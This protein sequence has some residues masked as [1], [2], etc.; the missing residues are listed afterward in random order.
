MSPRKPASLTDYIGD[1][2][3]LP[4]EVLLGHVVL[5]RI[6]DGAYDRDALSKQMDLLDLNTKYLPAINK[7]IDAYRKA[8]S[9]L[10]DREYVLD[11][12]TAH[13]LVRDTY[14]D[15]HV[16][17]RS[18]VREIRDSSGKRLA[19]GQVGEAVFHRTVTRGGKAQP[20]TARLKVTLLPSQLRTNER[21]TLDAIKAEIEANYDRHVNFID[22]MKIRAMV[23]GYLGH[24]NAVP[25]KDS[26]YFVHV[27]RRAEVSKLQELVLWLAGRANRGCTM[28]LIP[29]VDLEEQ[30][31]MVIAAYEDEAVKS[32]NE[33]I[34]DIQTLRAS[35]TKITPAAYAKIKQ[36]YNDI[37][38]ATAEYATKLNVKAERVADTA[39]VAL[40]TLVEL[41]KKLLDQ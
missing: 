2:G 4:D 32:L 26:V 21:T 23:R 30:R 1:T 7:E 31:E 41:Q 8:T 3:Q 37:T 6:G 16:L 29:L 39:E 13:L 40:E 33:V 34:T 36:K 18:L 27:A 28:S 25:L 35:R 15:E 17:H 24:L 38:K 12:D 20:G 10:D 19:Y 9:A 14:S 22:G 5:F 11:G